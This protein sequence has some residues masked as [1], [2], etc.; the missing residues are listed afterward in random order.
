MAGCFLTSGS[1]GITLFTA[2]IYLC[3]LIRCLLCNHLMCL[4]K[5]GMST[6]SNAIAKE[7]GWLC[8]ITD[9][10]GYSFSGDSG[11]FS[12]TEGS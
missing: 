10:Y 4:R 3:S 6:D 9:S 7:T 12:K 1:S 2:M 5:L 8:Y 11:H